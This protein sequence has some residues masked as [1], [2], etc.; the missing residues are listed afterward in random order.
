V[1]QGAVEL[2]P[3]GLGPGGLVAGRPEAGDDDGP[4]TGAAPAVAP[5]GLSPGFLAYVVG[6]IALALLLVLR[7][8]GLVAKVPVWAYAGAIVG[9]QVSGRLVERWPDAPP[10]S[11]RLHV[12][13]VVHVAAV[14]SVLYMSGWG[15]A[16]GMAFAFSA[17]A[18]LQQSGARAWRAALGWSLA[19]CAVGQV[20][21][22]EGWMPSFLSTAQAQTIGFLGAFVF[23]IAIRMAGA[24]GE[25]KERADALLA[26]QTT[27]AARARDDAQRSRDDAQRSEAHYR[28]VVENAAEG[29]LTISPDSTVGSFNAAAEAMFGWTATEIV[30]QPVAM[31]VPADLHDALGEFLATYRLIGPPAAQRSEV[32]I[33]GVRRDG[34][35]FPMMVSTSAITLDGSLPTVSAIVR[36]LSDQKR[37]EA[38]LAHQ[39][40]HDSL[41]GLPNRL[42]F[43][44]RLKQALARVRRHD[45]MFGVLFV[46]LDRFKAVNDTLGHTVGDQLLIEAAARIRSAVRETDTVA[47]LG[48]D[49]FVVLCEDIEGIH[50]ATDFAERII[51]V[52]QAP[53]RF[54]DDDTNVSASIGIA[55]SADGTETADAILAN[56]DIAMYRAKDNGRSRY[57]LFDETMQ[58]WITTQAALETDL[59]QSVA[60]NELRLFCQ[61]FIEADTGIIRGFEALVRWERPGFGLVMPDEIIPI[62]EE[63]GLIVDIGAWVL[64]Q[65][66]RH[67]ASWAQRWPD[68]RLGIAVN[69]SSRQLLTGDIVDVVTGALE[70]TGLD[71]TTLTLELTESTLIDD[72]VNAQALLHELR[73]LG[74]NL[75]LDDFGTGYSSLT[76]LRA[77]PISILKIDKSFVRAI[78]TERQ[79][80]AIVAA[81][82]ALAKNLGLSV[83]AEGVETNEQL[84]V[85]RKLHCPYMQGYLFSR[86]RPIDEATD[87]VEGPTLAVATARGASL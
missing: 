38:Q 27:Q 49:E 43:T 61:P 30:G 25:H 51:A 13:V 26:E 7:H 74:C 48:G 34:T 23:A 8:F 22:L 81:V 31:L 75:A 21:V 80:T 17:L 70:H 47:R 33:A 24:I 5:G 2:G 64:E 68:K 78:G 42:M 37:F 77:F 72:A 55:L 28:A 35:H 60:R 86:P 45:R 3:V 73:D 71:P 32:E 84:A 76:Y 36:D 58:Q 62:A 79:D 83:V 41:T 87:L 29:I 16:V 53:F 82:I 4:G 20:L 12:R 59:R 40:L 65:A 1:N 14:T 11:L 18:D 9:A 39:G 10:G 19:G 54:G 52:L 85:L 56:A 57:E 46:D 66:C 44:D 50:H 15:P 63:T 69:L 67:A 6:P